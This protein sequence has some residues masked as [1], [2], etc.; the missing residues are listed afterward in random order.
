M[1]GPADS[2]VSH[3]VSITRT[4]SDAHGAVHWGHPDFA[5]ANR[6]GTGMLGDGFHH[7]LGIVIKDE[8][9]EPDLSEQRRLAISGSACASG[10][11]VPSA[12]DEQAELPAKT[13]YLGHGQPVR[14]AVERTN[15][16]AGRAGRL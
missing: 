13:P 16:P 1:A 9:F 8:D 2:R 7:G 12:G 14:S 5:V 10:V 11:R 4:V 15:V 6:F 3:G